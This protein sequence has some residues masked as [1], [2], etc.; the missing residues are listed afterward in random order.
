M[1]EWAEALRAPPG[2]EWWELAAGGASSAACHALL[3]IAAT[4]GASAAEAELVDAAYFPSVGA[5]TVLLDDLVDREADRH[6]G[7]HN[8]LD[9]YDPTASLTGRLEAIVAAARAAAQELPDRRRH[10]AILAGVLAF[11]LAA[12][13]SPASPETEA[14]RVAA[15]ARASA[16]TRALARALSLSA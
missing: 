11:Y 2:F 1:R 7:E 15:L 12:P 3:A 8:F 16:P 10:Q 13:S 6:A 5:L 9:Y 14:A 4:P